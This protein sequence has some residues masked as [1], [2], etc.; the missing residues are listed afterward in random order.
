MEIW[1]N[2][3][4]PKAVN[5]GKSLTGI[6][7]FSHFKW[8][9]K[10]VKTNQYKKNHNILCLQLYTADLPCIWTRN[11][12]L[13]RR[14]ASLSFSLLEPQSESISSM[15]MMEGLFSLARLKRVFTNLENKANICE[16]ILKQHPLEWLYFLW[17]VVYMTYFS[18][19]P[20]HLETRSD[21]EME[22]KVEL[23][24]SVATALAR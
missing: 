8:L 24:A 2:S 10:K 16:K 6:F 20:S 19:S 9:M 22:K 7:Q 11:S 21:E 5:N 18:L 13:I 14:A 3:S 23:F 17:I 1:K 15:N 12:V 4:D